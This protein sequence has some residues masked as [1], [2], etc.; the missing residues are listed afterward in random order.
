MRW[1]ILVFLLCFSFISADLV[2]TG[3]RTFTINGANVSNYNELTT[4]GT[5]SDNICEVYCYG[6]CFK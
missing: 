1:V 3:T 4:K 2:S 6:G 5:D